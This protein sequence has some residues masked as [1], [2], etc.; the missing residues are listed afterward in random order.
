MY[1]GKQKGWYAGTEQR[2]SGSFLIVLSKGRELRG[3]VRSVRMAQCGHFMMGRVTVAGESLSLS[4]TYGSDGLPLDG[5]RY[6][7]TWDVAVPFPETLAEAFWKGGGHNC[8]GSEGPGVAQWARENE[9]ALRRSVPVPVVE[10]RLDGYVPLRLAQ[11]W[12][13]CAKAALPTYGE[14]VF[15]K[16][17]DFV[18]FAPDGKGLELG[19]VLGVWNGAMHVWQ[20]GT[21]FG[22]GMIRRVSAA[23]VTAVL[24]PKA[25]FLA[26]FF[27]PELPDA[28]G[29]KRLR[30]EGAV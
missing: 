7:Q 25:A 12:V 17:G 26:T 21:S 28:E 14:G 16:P 10:L 29:F 8:A 23:D 9:R 6:P 24:W 4:G 11:K 3:I 22:Y 27:A 30:A 15:V 18:R 5:E 1:V 2:A 19:R 13:W 20:V